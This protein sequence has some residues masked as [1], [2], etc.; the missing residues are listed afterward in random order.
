ME[1]V[2]QLA[3]AV[4]HDFNN[5][6][7]VILGNSELGLAA[8]DK[9]KPVHKRL[10]EIKKAAKLAESLTGQLLAFSRKH[11]LK[12]K[13]LNLND[14]ILNTQ[15][16]LKRLIREDIKLVIKTCPDLADIKA[17]AVQIEQ[18]LMNLVINA[19]D[20]LPDGGKIIIETENVTIDEAYVKHHEGS[21]EGRFVMFSVSDNGCGMDSNTKYHIFDPFFTTKEQGKG[22]G[23]GLATV[24]GIIK[25]TSGN[26]WV[27]SEK[28]IGTTFKIYLP[29]VNEQRTLP[30][31]NRVQNSELT[32]S[33][34][35]LIV[36]DE[37]KVRGIIADILNEYG[38]STLMA[39]D[40]ESALGICD[41]YKHKIQLVLTD[42]IMP[43]MNGRQMAEKL[44][45]INPG[46]K[47]LFMSGYTDNAIVYN[48]LLDE[49][50]QFIP[51]PVSPLE[52][53]T[54]IRK[55]L[56]E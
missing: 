32:G 49:G 3:G 48:G 19:S 4:A 43:Q 33:E 35:I 15:K 55:L 28:G 29:Q 27:Y 25:Q 14:L 11:I 47:I 38:Y 45:T 30:K 7:T 52:L 53:T 17:D 44:H 8:V 54:K 24:Y 39:K 31:Q 56:D 1:T 22:T 10:H 12:P 42:I 50:N 9:N 46:L 2:G 51:K 18:V 26:I 20:A 6:L 16:M 23:M 5:L 37:N 41:K 36:E 13:M 21:R 34:T 40:G